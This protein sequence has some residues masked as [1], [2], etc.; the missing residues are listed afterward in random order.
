MANRCFTKGFPF[1]PRTNQRFEA[2]KPQRKPVE[3]L[4]FVTAPQN[5]GSAT[6]RE[7]FRYLAAWIRKTPH[8]KNCIPYSYLRCSLR[9]GTAVTLSLHWNSS[10]RSLAGFVG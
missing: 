5:Y 8:A 9:S 7:A 10:R 2:I 6:K 4:G 3:N 1:A